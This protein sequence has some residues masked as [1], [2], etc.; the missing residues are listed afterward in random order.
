M[1][2]LFNIQCIAAPP[3]KPQ[4]EGAVKEG[5][6]Q[7]QYKDQYD[8]NPDP[9][10]PLH[11]ITLQFPHSRLDNKD[12]FRVALGDPLQLDTFIPSQVAVKK[13]YTFGVD[14]LQDQL[15]IDGPF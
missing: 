8:L 4:I 14:D 9:G 2:Q 1:Q 10:F 6:H 3:Q 11:W 7:A 5:H 15:A 12:H 13:A